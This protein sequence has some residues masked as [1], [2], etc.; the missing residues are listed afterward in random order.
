MHRTSAALIV[1][2]LLLAGCGP[3][4]EGTGSESDSSRTDHKG[5][6]PALANAVAGDCIAGEYFDTDDQAVAW[7]VDCQEFDRLPQGRGGGG[8]RFKRM[9]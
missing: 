4:E 6:D 2:V 1:M 3:D 5:V 8:G 9:P 7:P